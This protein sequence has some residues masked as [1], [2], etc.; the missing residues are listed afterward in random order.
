MWIIRPVRS[1]TTRS[2][3]RSSRAVRSQNRVI[4]TSNPD[5]G[6]AGPG[7]GLQDLLLG[8]DPHQ[9]TR[10]QVGPRGG[11]EAG[12]A[13]TQ[14]PPAQP[15]PDPQPPRQH[16]PARLLVPVEQRDQQCPQRPEHPYLAG[17]DVPYVLP[18]V[19]CRHRLR[20][21]PEQLGGLAPVGLGAVGGRLP[22]ARG[23]QQWKEPAVA[24]RAGRT[25][26]PRHRRVRP[27]EP[28]DSRRASLG[29]RGQPGGRRS[30]T[31]VR[32]SAQRHWFAPALSGIGSLQRS[33]AL[34][35]SSAQRHWFAPA[36][37]GIGSLQRS[38]ALVRSSAHRPASR[39]TIGAA[40]SRLPPRCR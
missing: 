39:S 8:P 14:E 22:A 5:P 32:S 40:A 13:A 21:R 1:S 4:S 36:L 25:R 2:T 37:S 16:P 31:L 3:R 27:L 24:G 19:A 15:A 20:G 35:R 34:V 6:C 30:A 10:P 11:G 23:R 17:A 12:R 29:A 26:R 33:A 28:S 38:A 9:L 7:Q 18:Q